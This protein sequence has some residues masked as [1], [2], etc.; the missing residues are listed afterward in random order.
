MLELLQWRHKS[1]GL[2]QSEAH[3][4]KALRVATRLQSPRQSLRKSSHSL[5]WLHILTQSKSK[6]IINLKALP[7]SSLFF[8]HQPVLQRKLSSIMAS[9]ATTPS[10]PVAL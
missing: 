10:G 6:G 7:L 4:E 3:L 1:K 2:A 9:T 5:G 8:L